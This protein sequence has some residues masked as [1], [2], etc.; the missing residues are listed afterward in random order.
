MTQSPH[1]GRKCELV[2]SLTTTWWGSGRF[3]GS[4]EICEHP[5]RTSSW[6]IRWQKHN[7]I[8][9]LLG[10]LGG[11]WSH[12]GLHYV[13][14][15]AKESMSRSGGVKQ[16]LD[17]DR[18]TLE[19]TDWAFVV[20]FLSH[21]LRDS[22]LSTTIL[23]GRSGFRVPESEVVCF[24]CSWWNMTANCSESFYHFLMLNWQSGKLT[25]NVRR[26]HWENPVGL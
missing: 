11:P 22:T 12:Y 24:P 23:W 9:S 19:A 21:L 6:A 17:A 4:L 5:T 10:T 15:E 14:D 16:L 18:V 8:L 3:P 1:T 20:P 2:R 25:I 13:V 26:L 7:R